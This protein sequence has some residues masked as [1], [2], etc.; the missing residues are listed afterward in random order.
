[1]INLKKLTLLIIGVIIAMNPANAEIIKCK[2]KDTIYVFTD[3]KKHC[4]SDIEI[5]SVNAKNI[6]GK[7]KNKNNIFSDS[8][9]IPN[10]NDFYLGATY[11]YLSIKHPD[12]LDKTTEITYVKH[13]STVQ[14]YKIDG[15]DIL[16][17]WISLYFY[18]GTFV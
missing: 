4:A 15:E 11:N 3:S 13:L 8:H 14:I 9:S 16:S 10:Y 6:N 12:R 18:E 5:I 17:N 7:V 2:N 1:M